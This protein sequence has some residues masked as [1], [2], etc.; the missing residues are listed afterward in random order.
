MILKADDLGCAADGR[1]LREVS[2]TAGSASLTVPPGS[3]LAVDVGASISVPGA[4]DM[5]ATIADMPEAKKVERAT[6]TAGEHDLVVH[7][8]SENRF[9]GDHKGWR[10]VVDGAG[11]SGGPLVTDIE[12]VGKW[13]GGQQVLV[14][15]DSAATSIEDTTAFANDGSRA[16]LS[17]HARASVGPLSLAVNGRPVQDAVMIVGSKILRSAEARFSRLDIG[18]S[19]TIEGAGHYRTTV[20]EVT[21]D[22][23]VVL[24]DP[25]QRTVVN[26]PADVWRPESDCAPPVRAML[27]TAAD[28]GGPVEIEFGAGVYDFTALPLVGA[29]SCA[30]RL[31]GLSDLT[32]RGAGRGVTVL[33]LMPEQD[34]QGAS[35][36]VDDTH[37]ILAKGCMSLKITGLTVHG[38]YLT[39][40][41]GGVEQMHGVFLGAGCGE[42]DLD[43]IEVF[44]SA[45]DGVRLLGADDN[46]THDIR[47]DRCRL[48]QNHRSGVAV[49]REVHTTRI[50]GCVIDMTPPGEDACIDLEPTG[51][52]PAQAP[53]DVIIDFNTL[54]HGNAAVAVSLSGIAAERP[55]RRIRFARNTLTGGRLGGRHT[56]ELTLRDN[57]ID[58]GDADVRGAMVRLHG[59][60]ADLRVEGNQVLAAGE[61]A[62]GITAGG[63][64]AAQ[65]VVVDNVVGTAGL[66]IEV[67]TSGDGVEVRGNEVRGQNNR[68]GIR[69]VSV[70]KTTHE[71]I[72]VRDNEV[73]D[74]GRAGIVVSPG[75]APDTL[76]G[77]VIT[78]N[79]IDGGGPIGIELGGH[80]GQWTEAVV[81]DNAIGAGIPVP[82]HGPE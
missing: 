9:V 3:V 59:R 62:D 16:K 5:V 53:R 28:S 56:E 52:A 66:G 23:T 39:M 13:S 64:D 43:D 10:I 29:A 30:M 1:W 41:L 61:Q 67:V 79:S 46:P 12:Q 50:R 73:R 7:L 48:T 75:E 25:A 11:P 18:A 36:G 15:A 20:E 26:G 45:G 71:G 8:T 24:A 47:V 57:T 14:L 78:G 63:K 2:I 17:D 22:A 54:V 4:A 60:C 70:G 72:V 76:V 42:V 35:P 82:I 31:T 68:P 65:M 55:A 77:P 51:K 81:E 37:V 32:L 33:R 69:V 6:I 58:A 49:Q 74:F 19:V 27:Q 34:L 21:G 40:A 44:Q 38:A 80:E